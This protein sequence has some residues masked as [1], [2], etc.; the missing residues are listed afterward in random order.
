MAT[1]GSSEFVRQVQTLFGPGSMAGL[2]D[3]ELLDRFF[4]RRAE[5]VEALLAAEAAFAALVARHGPMVLGVCRRALDDPTDVDDA[6]QATFL[7]LVRRAGAVRVGDSLGQWLYGVARKVTSRTRDR[8]AQRRSRM[9]PL[10]VEPQAPV[11]AQ[12]ELL[13]ALDEE[14]SRLPWRYRTP[15]ILCYLEGLSQAEA[16]ARLKCPVGTVSGRLT[17]ARRLLR[18]RLLRRGLAST[19]VLGEFLVSER[20][21]AAIPDVLATATAR[22]AARLTM[23]GVSHVGAASSSSFALMHEVVRAGTMARLGWAVVAVLTLGLAGFSAAAVHAEWRSQNAS[24]DVEAAATVIPPPGGSAAN[25]R[26]ADEIVR[27]L[28]ALLKIARRVSSSQEEWNRT[29]GGIASLAEELRTA[30]PRDPRVGRYLPERWVAL[31]Y[32]Y[33]RPEALDE[34]KAILRTTQDRA[35]HTDARFY[36]IMLHFQEPIDSLS[37]VALAEEFARHA[38]SDPRAG[39]LLFE[40]SEKLEAGRNARLGLFVM[41][42]L[43]AGLLLAWNRRCAKLAIRAGKLS[44][45]AATVFVL[46]LGI[47][48]RDGV[49]GAV[50]LLYNAIHD[51]DRIHKATQIALWLAAEAARY[52]RDLPRGGH[53]ALLLGLAVAAAAGLARV[54]RSSVDSG[55]HRLHVWRRVA[56]DFLVTLGLLCLVDAGVI[57]WQRSALLDR[58]LLAYPDS[59]RGRL[60]Q[61]QRR[62]VQEV[63]KPFELEFTDAI[64]GRR[65]AMKDLRGQVVVVNFWATWCGPCAQEIPELVRVYERYHDQGVEFLGVSLDIPE[66]DGGLEALKGFVAKHNISWPQYFQGHENQRIL[67]GEPTGD[68]SESWGITAIPTVFLI[69]AEGRLFLTN[70]RGELDTLIPRLLAA[71]NKSRQGG[72]PRPE[73]LS[74]P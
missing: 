40:A 69:D 27:E 59:F 50:A 61:G 43:S 57:A 26:P 19:C 22:A 14:I 52:L 15:M 32:L 7:V 39:E 45:V 8:V 71:R 1:Q 67:T 63:G 11:T 54:R 47:F 49:A 64:S 30:Y 46:G 28:E 51:S 23:A 13:E 31:S 16:A 36:D 72:H 68:F 37:A 2:T 73:T 4:R 24:T 55:T 42:L 35:L 58:I 20:V 70:A 12:D 29:F 5:A 21:R 38:P 60:V 3:A 9:R 74:Q 62:Q 56:L 25:H 33:R 65:I 66:A 6:F 10:E 41:C 34:V 44:L 18:D 53:A 17:R 48:T